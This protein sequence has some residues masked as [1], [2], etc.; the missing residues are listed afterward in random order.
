MEEFELRVVSF[1]QLPVPYEKV[2][3]FEYYQQVINFPENNSGQK[4]LLRSRIFP[5]N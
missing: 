2:N 1:E 5:L 3:Y 4:L